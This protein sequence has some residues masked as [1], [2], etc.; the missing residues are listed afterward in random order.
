MRATIAFLAATAACG[1]SSGKN[2][3]NFEGNWPNISLTTTVNCG[4]QTQTANSTVAIGISAGNGA[5]LEYT[6]TAGCDFKFMVSGNTANLANAPVTCSTTSSGTTFVLNFTSY[7]LTTSD[8]HHLTLTA[9]GTAAS[10][11]TTCTEALT[12]SGTR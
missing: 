2:L 12:G 10:G 7:S 11:G 1:G 4:G 3:S 5:D 9:G 8:G 6:S